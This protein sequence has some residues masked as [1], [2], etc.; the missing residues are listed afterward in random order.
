MIRA[1]Y[2]KEIHPKAVQ[3]YNRQ[4]RHWNWQTKEHKMINEILNPTKNKSFIINCIEDIY[5]EKHKL[6]VED[7]IKRGEKVPEKVLKEYG[8][9]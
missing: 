6:A 8:F 9:K 4:V 2:R 3:E 7:A 1:K 5:L